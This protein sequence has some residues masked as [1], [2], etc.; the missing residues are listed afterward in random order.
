M[1][2]TANH[3]FWP[4]NHLHK[5]YVKVS[6]PV[7]HAALA[8]NLADT[9]GKTAKILA[10]LLGTMTQAIALLSDFWFGQT[11]VNAGDIWIQPN[12]QH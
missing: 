2:N 8:C 3:S 1:E 4:Q 10:A 9:P 6:R 12:Q 5:G 7:E 11:S